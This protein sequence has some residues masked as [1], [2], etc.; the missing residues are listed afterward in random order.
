ME[1][2]LVDGLVDGL[3]GGQAA[4]LLDWECKSGAGFEPA[5]SQ[6]LSKIDVIQTKT[7]GIKGYQRL[8]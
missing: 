5:Q 1:G 2:S 3:Q 8:S 7:I 4:E 6:L